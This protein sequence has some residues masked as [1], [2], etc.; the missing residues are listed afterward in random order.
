MNN[1][2]FIVNIGGGDDRN[3]PYHYSIK[4][5]KSWAD[6]NNAELFVLTEHV[7]ES[8]YMH[9]NWHKSLA[10]KLLKENNIE[11][12][13]VLIVDADTI[14]HPDCPNFFE[15][16]EG[17]FCG[18]VNEGCYEWVTR[19][20][21]NYGDYIFPEIP[22]IKPWEYFNSGFI[23]ANKTHKEFFDN[24]LQYYHDNVDKFIHAKSFHVGNDQTPLNYFTKKFNV[25]TKLLPSC[26]NL[27]DMA[28]KTLFT[29]G[30]KNWSEDPLFLK[31]GWV[32]HFN[33][34]PANMGDVAYWMEYTYNKLYL[35]K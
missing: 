31:A 11:F 24:V 2:I 22:K 12:D 15:E 19:S 35:N 33:A 8:D 21:E 5:W 27:Q 17:K 26:Y 9:L 23:I 25:E 18:V 16:T 34:I 14:V 32:Y 7:Y 10:I 13:Q 1:I 4:S 3:K 28:R 6:K 30:Y 29:S 20:I